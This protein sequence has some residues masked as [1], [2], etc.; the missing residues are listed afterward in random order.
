MVWLMTRFSRLVER[1]RGLPP[2]TTEAGAPGT[3]SEA[4]A[5]LVGSSLGSA[6]R[7]VWMTVSEGAVGLG[8][9]LLTQPAMT[10]KRGS[11]EPVKMGRLLGPLPWGTRTTERSSLLE[12]SSLL[13]S[14]RVA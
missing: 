7:R 6:P 12:G 1:G 10:L 3:R 11:L 5:L 14:W 2:R 4:K 8:R 9:R 13:M